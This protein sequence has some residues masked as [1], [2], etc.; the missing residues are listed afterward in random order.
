M[1]APPSTHL[2]TVISTPEHLF[3]DCFTSC[4]QE[5]STL[6]LTSTPFF[7]VLCFFS[8]FIVITQLQKIATN[9]GN[10]NA[11][12]GRGEKFHASPRCAL[13]NRATFITAE[14]NIL[15]CRMMHILFSWLFIVN[16]TKVSSLGVVRGEVVTAQHSAQ[17]HWVGNNQPSSTM[18][19]P[20]H[21]LY[22]EEDAPP[23]P[24]MVGPLSK[25]IPHCRARALI[26]HCHRNITFKI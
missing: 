25:H 7:H 22:P 24:G 10:Y 8:S 26:Q 3:P 12:Q 2:P 6:R 13:K 9:Q 14:S 21:S 15:A 1:S 17:V 23:S 20:Q 11:L 16:K 4:C 18:L 5:F 19:H